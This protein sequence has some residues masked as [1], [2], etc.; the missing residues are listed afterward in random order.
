MASTPIQRFLQHSY[1][2]RDRLL[3]GGREALYDE[4]MRLLLQDIV[5]YVVRGRRQDLSQH[6]SV[7]VYGPRYAGPQTS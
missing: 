6:S 5:P 2:V 4:T 7:R 3:E 1:L